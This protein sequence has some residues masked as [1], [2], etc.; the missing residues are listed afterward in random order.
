[1]FR[2]RSG[3]SLCYACGK[4]NRLDAAV[5]FYCGVRRPGLWGFGPLL[6]RA[7]GRLDVARVVIAVCVVA[8]AASLLLDPAAALRPRSAFDFLAP[9]NAA[10]YALGAAGTI[11]WAGGRWWTV[12]TAIYLHGSLLHIL[13]NMM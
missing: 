11:P 9:G 4:L 7:V 13:F 5:C 2:Q 6:G 8:Y 3:S 1:M 12:F 10:L